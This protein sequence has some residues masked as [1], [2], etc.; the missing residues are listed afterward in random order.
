MESDNKRTCNHCKVNLPVSHFNIKRNGEYCKQCIK[1][2]NDNK[3]YRN[4]IKCEHLRQRSRCKDCK[5][6]SICEHD[7]RRSECKECHGR[8]ICEHN[9]I[10]SQCKECNLQGCIRKN[11]LTRMCSVLGYS[12]FEYLG[13]T[14]EEF[15]AHIEG[16]FKEGMTWENYGEWQIDHIKPLGVKGL[17]EEE[18]IER[19]EFTNT[20]PLWAADNIRKRNKDL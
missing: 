10:R 3:K 6:G 18:I 19:F 12:N 20:Q 14:I 15:I 2:N 5:G 13:C 1:C 17:T 16:E 11:I 8:S 7:R 4:T 9:R